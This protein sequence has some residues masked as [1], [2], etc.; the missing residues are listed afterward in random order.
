MAPAASASAACKL[1]QLGEIPVT[2]Q[3]LEPVIEAKIN[4]QPVHLVADSGFFYS[5]IDSTEA[6]RLK[7]ST[8]TEPHD[9]VI[10]LRGVNGYVNAV[11]KVAQEFTILGRPFK[12]VDFIAAPLG[13]DSNISGYLGQNFLNIANT[14]YDLANGAIRLFRLDGC[15]NQAMVYWDKTDPYSEIPIVNVT[16]DLTDIRGTVS[17]N[18]V[19]LSAQFDTGA[20]YSVLSLRGAAKAGIKRDDATFKPGGL[21]RGIAQR[22]EQTWIVPVQSFKIG[23]EEIRNTRLRV[24]EI[25]L[26]N[27]DMLIGADF[28]LSHRIFVANTQRKLYFTYNGGPVFRLEEI[29]ASQ[30]AAPAAASPPQA[31]A[32]AA[33]SGG[34][35]QDAEGLVRRAHASDARHAYADAIADYT[36]ALALAPKDPKILLARGQA[37]IDNHQLDLAGADLD[38]ALALNPDDV[39]ARMARAGLHLRQSPALARVDFD[40]AER[41]DRKV[42]P[43]IGASYTEVG[44]YAQ[45]VAEFDAWLADLPKGENGAEGYNDRCWARALWNHDLDKA[46][47]D[48]NQ[49]LRLAPGTFGYLDSRGLTNLRLAHYDDAIRDYDAAL[50]QQPKYAWTMYCRGVA[51]VKAGRTAEGEAD[52]K[53]AVGI[54]PEVVAK[55]KRYELM[56][57]TASRPRADSAN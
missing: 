53:A 38:Q 3:G 24:S 6:L 19:E 9:S 17:V 7:M 44:N 31:T 52:M 46:L 43:G 45:A 37:Y 40:A 4:G 32:A 10:G 41:L 18:G 11:L 39:D 54:D 12:D 42:M 30:P 36:R 25:Q 8:S 33:P 27:V 51:K 15:E 29:A 57:G 5:A 2:M 26:D 28:F 55:V 1:L 21:S 34:A 13:L 22:L 49:A 14:E 50:R 23:D 56:D 35:P 47:A 16:R 20:S 48:C